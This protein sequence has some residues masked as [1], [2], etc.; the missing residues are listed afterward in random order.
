MV[1][2]L[3]ERSQA[4]PDLYHRHPVRATRSV[5]ALLSNF[6]TS[7]PSGTRASGEVPPRV[8]RIAYYKH[9]N[10]KLKG[11]KS[12]NSYDVLAVRRLY[13]IAGDER[14]EFVYA[15]RFGAPQYSEAFIDWMVSEYEKNARFFDRT[16]SGCR[17]MALT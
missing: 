8:H 15:P 4:L 14:P 16:R 12:I 5:Q 11:R 1:V 10:G 13:G 7:S 6:T 2:L 17:R 3:V 9:L